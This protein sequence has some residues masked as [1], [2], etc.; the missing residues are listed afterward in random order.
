MSQTISKSHVY[1]ALIRCKSGKCVIKGVVVYP[2]RFRF[3]EL[4]HT[5]YAQ[6][7][8]VTASVLAV[9]SELGNGIALDA[10]TLSTTATVHGPITDRLCGLLRTT[11]TLT[12]RVQFFTVE[13]V[14]VE[15]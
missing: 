13:L 14:A 15:F 6:V 9:E 1:F 10:V 12:F 2:D 5:I 3:I 7:F 8:F 11:S 4:E